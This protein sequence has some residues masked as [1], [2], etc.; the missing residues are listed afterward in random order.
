MKYLTMEIKEK[1]KY[2][3]KLL[4]TQYTISRKKT[5]EI[6]DL[7]AKLKQHKGINS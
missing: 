3:E 6:E 4:E 2:F 1:Q 7:K 5:L